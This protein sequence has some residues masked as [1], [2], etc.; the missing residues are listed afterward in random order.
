MTI[1]LLE[2]DAANLKLLQ[3]FLERCGYATIAVTN[4]EDAVG[5]GDDSSQ[6]IDLLLADVRLPGNHGFDVA[7]R[8]RRKRPELPILFMS[9]YPL[10]YVEN[11]TGQPARLESAGF[12]FL[13]KPFTR[14]DLQAKIDQLFHRLR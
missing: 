3:H 11:G 2:D 10:D 1:L 7:G 4:E 12:H 5:I 14:A 13:Q 8:I 9:G 6:E